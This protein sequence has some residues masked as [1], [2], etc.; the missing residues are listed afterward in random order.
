MTSP[1]SNLAGLPESWTYEPLSSNES[2]RLF[3]LWTAQDY[4]DPLVGSVT[5]Y[6]LA[7]LDR[8]YFAL[9]Y[10]W[11]QESDPASVRDGKQ[12]SRELAITRNLETALRHLRHICKPFEKNLILW[13]D[14]ICI[15]QEDLEEKSHQI[16]LMCDIYQ[17]ADSV[18]IWLGKENQY[19]DYQ[20]MFDY[21]CI[22]FNEVKPN[23]DDYG[24]LREEQEDNAPRLEQ[25]YPKLDPNSSPAVAFRDFF[26]NTPWFHRAWTM[27][28]SVVAQDKMFLCGEN[29]LPDPFRLMPSLYELASQLEALDSGH[30]KWIN[31]CIPVPTLLTKM[32][33][34]W[35]KHAADGKSPLSFAQ[36]LGAQ[37][38]AGCKD[39]RDI[40]YSVLGL[41][42]DP[43]FDRTRVV[44]DYQKPVAVVYA[45]AF[46][47]IIR[48]ERSIEVLNGIDYRVNA[49]PDY[50]LPSWVPNWEIRADRKILSY[51]VARDA[52]YHFHAATST[53]PPVLRI[54]RDYRELM[55]AGMRITR[56]ESV[57]NKE[58]RCAYATV[59][60]DDG[61]D[62]KSN[63]TEVMREISG[64]A[65]AKILLRQD[66]ATGRRVFH[67]AKGGLPDGSENK[68]NVAGHNLLVSIIDTVGEEAF[69]F[70]PKDEEQEMRDH[71]TN[72]QLIAVTLPSVGRLART[73]RGSLAI[74]NEVTLPGDVIIAAFGGQ[75]PLI[76][77]P[78]EDKYIFIGECFL[79]GF[80]NGEALSSL[81][82]ELEVN[83]PR[84]HKDVG[85]TPASTTTHSSEPGS[86]IA[87]EI[88]SPSNISKN[89]VPIIEE[90][91]HWV[92]END[93]ANGEWFIL[94]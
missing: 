20:G 90:S 28:E 46:A 30:T 22:L 72:D 21:L 52:G 76:L 67:L 56:I 85:G 57:V 29:R 13:I 5:E 84:A 19:A 32:S 4:D 78:Q 11:G 7:H 49:S 55:I 91:K 31:H 81:Q 34:N 35:T 36:C 88:A 92:P 8:K 51:S 94:V 37:R 59:K 27:Q 68:E 3:E 45:E 71:S 18:F 23:L 9:S 26:R 69:R 14:S 47:E 41:V 75:A 24:K 61:T 82:Q 89:W 2:F 53:G 93:P 66:Q 62:R 15:N 43:Q 25:F 74:V 6:T 12:T 42:Q 40:V 44:P 83:D 50:G 65:D 73:E 54:S 38:G 58:L 87:Y 70:W 60:W 77:R 80:M 64:K 17:K 79:S 10:V 33:F 1:A 63:V 48:S 16:P 86:P 39:A